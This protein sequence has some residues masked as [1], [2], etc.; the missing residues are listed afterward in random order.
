MQY[1]LYEQI[2]DA[3][4]IILF[5]K[6]E[7]DNLVSISTYIENFPLDSNS[8][9]IILN[10]KPTKPL[11][12]LQLGLT[13]L[14]DEKELYNIILECKIAKEYHNQIKEGEFDDHFLKHNIAKQI[15][16]NIFNIAKLH[17]DIYFEKYHSKNKDDS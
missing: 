3:E 9:Y 6:F 17:T 15:S 11:N 1:E 7:T 14:P 4:N 10:N 2:F 12:Y 16:N 13:A 5:Y 8:K